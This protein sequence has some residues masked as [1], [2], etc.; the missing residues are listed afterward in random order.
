MAVRVVRQ[1]AKPKP[2]Y[3]RPRGV[4]LCGFCITNDHDMCPGQV[5]N[6]YGNKKVP[7][8]ECPCWLS[9]KAIHINARTL[10]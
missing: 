6:G 7:V 1:R 9:N 4:A 5:R 2:P 8:W 3:Q 10:E